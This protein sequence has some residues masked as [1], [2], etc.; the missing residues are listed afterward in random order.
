MML[1][2]GALEHLNVGFASLSRQ[3][4]EPLA[5]GLALIDQLLQPGPHAFG[6]RVRGALEQLSGEPEGTFL[7]CE[8]VVHE[9]LVGVLDLLED[10]LKFL[11]RSLVVHHLYDHSLLLWRRDG[12][13]AESSAKES[14]VERLWSANR[15]GGR[16]HEVSAPLS[17]GPFTKEA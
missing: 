13:T 9:G 12:R 4:L 8:D 10:L 2:D 16:H 7:E 6:F 14:T 17:C 15:W 5:F 3:P 1:I 11:L